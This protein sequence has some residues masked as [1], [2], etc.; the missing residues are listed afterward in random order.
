MD[1]MKWLI[2]CLLSDFP[3]LTLCYPTTHSLLYYW[4]KHRVNQWISNSFCFQ[5]HP[6]SEIFVKPWS[7]LPAWWGLTPAKNN[8]GNWRWCEACPKIV[9]FTEHVSQSFLFLFFFKKRKKSFLSHFL[10]PLQTSW[11]TMAHLCLE[12]NHLVTL[13]FCSI[14]KLTL[15]MKREEHLCILNFFHQYCSTSTVTLHSTL[16]NYI[17]RWTFHRNCTYRSYFL[18]KSVCGVAAWNGPYM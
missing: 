2:H 5:K 15:Q 14:L 7:A 1:V 10:L 9:G 11:Y 16:I 4:K 8:W 3:S 13:V 17:E 12:R 6:P 18:G